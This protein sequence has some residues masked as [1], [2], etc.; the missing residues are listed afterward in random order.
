MYDSLLLLLQMFNSTILHDGDTPV[1]GLDFENIYDLIDLSSQP[2]PEPTEAT[3]LW[4]SIGFDDEPHPLLAEF[5]NEHYVELSDI[6]FV[7]EWNPFLAPVDYHYPPANDGSYGLGNIY[8]DNALDPYIVSES[9][10]TGFAD[11][12]F[13]STFEV[14]PDPAHTDTLQSYVLA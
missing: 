14:F 6:G 3:A 13:P 10:L 2:V 12:Q 8:P 11:D 1:P 5:A 7:G 4:D 9:E